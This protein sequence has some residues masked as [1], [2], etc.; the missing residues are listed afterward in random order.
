M[1]ESFSIIGFLVVSL[2]GE[3]ILE[4]IFCLWFVSNQS[5][6]ITN[7]KNEIEKSMSN[8]FIHKFITEKN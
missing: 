1:R 2:A 7:W 6:S 8:L 5:T 4:M 3:L